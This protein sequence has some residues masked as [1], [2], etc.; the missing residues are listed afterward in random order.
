M[1]INRKDIGYAL[2]SR[3]EESLR[4]WISSKLFQ[5][6]GNDWKKEVPEGIWNKLSDKLIAEEITE[7][8]EPQ[9]LLEE[10]DLP[11]LMDIVCYKKNFD[12][13]IGN[14]TIRKTDFRDL[15]IKLYE[16][17]IKIA[18]VKSNFS[19]IDL[20]LLCDI[21]TKFLETFLSEY[22]EIRDILICIRTNPDAIQINIPEEFY[23]DDIRDKKLPLN[24][25]PVNDYDADGGFIGR[26][27]DL[28][29]INK[30]LVGDLYRVV[31]ISGA[32]GVGKSAIAHFYCQQLLQSSKF[33]FDALVWVSAKEEKL[34]LTG[35]EPIESTLRNYEDVLNSILET[36]AWNEETNKTL[37]E[38]I[39]LVDLI[40]K[41][42]DKGILLVIDNLETIRDERIKDFI[43]SIPPPNKVLI[44]SR[45]G[46]GEVEI[47]H[48]L[49]EMSTKD[50]IILLRTVAKEKNAISL[51]KLSD[52][53][54]TAYVAK[55]SSYPLAIK[56]VVGQVAVGKDINLV[57]QHLTSPTGD[58]AKFCFEYI[59]ER[60]L[61]DS[62]RLILYSLAFYDVPLVRGVLTH[63]TNLSVEE[64][65]DSIRELNIA[66]LVIPKLVAAKNVIE[67]KY[68]LLPLTRNFIQAKLRANNDLFL[69]IK[70][71]S[72]LIDN[73]LEEA[74]KAG[75]Q[76]RYS[77]QSMGANTEEEKIAATWATTAFQKFQAGN[78]DG[79]VNDFKKASEIAPN[80]ANVY[81]NWALM[82]SQAGYGDKANE[83][84]KKATGI[85]PKDSFLWFTWGNIEKQKQRLNISADYLQKALSLSSN[86]IY[87]LGALGEVEKRRG[88]YAKADKLLREAIQFAR[89]ESGIIS[90]TK[91]EVV[92]LTSLA[93]NNRRWAEILNSSKKYEDAHYK[94]KFASECAKKAMKLSENDPKAQETH[95]EVSLAMALA[96]MY[97]K[98]DDL[99][100]EKFFKSA[101]K[102]SPKGAK[103]KRITSKSCFYYTNYLIGQGNLKKAQVYFSIGKRNLLDGSQYSERYRVL[104]KKIG[105]N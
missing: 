37:D 93:D 7:I 89:K 71:R 90:K 43:K 102:M 52:D 87:I 54:L 94:L 53:V 46:L 77:L 32:G 86:D 35:I 36:Y 47:R 21:A 2:Y 44:T 9:I 72:S 19:A 11:D 17:R 29:K 96:L 45:K 18:H 6:S 60:L 33:S 5:I 25:L 73:L 26:R 1:Q 95:M 10:T 41:A 83:L 28:A 39:L 105:K 22:S 31:T 92:C 66:S 75:T 84:M 88:N 48:Q 14:N 13:F 23:L 50:A 81:K 38:K 68:E 79:A 104:E 42:S 40:I 67:T 76:Y 20:D 24:N 70:K 64:L 99:S 100:I 30:L 69:E 62:E 57:L 55:M 34:T 74:E 15:M 101:I 49:K 63:L 59:F 12:F 51:S 8:G 27:D 4:N 98:K 82:E 85:N 91:H 58:V 65:D 56:W 103:Q 16:L 61:N 80:F 3:V 97:N 78:Y